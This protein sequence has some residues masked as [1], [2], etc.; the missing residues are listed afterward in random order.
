LHRT[1]LKELPQFLLLFQPRQRYLGLTTHTLER[2][3]SILSI[4]RKAILRV[5]HIVS[6]NKDGLMLTH[7]H[8]GLMILLLSYNNRVRKDSMSHM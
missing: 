1:V 6:C 5:S 2:D 8:G 4:E 7:N 3:T